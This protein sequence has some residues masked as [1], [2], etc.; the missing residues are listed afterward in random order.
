MEFVILGLIIIVIIATINNFKNYK[1]ENEITEADDYYAVDF[2]TDS[3][4]KMIRVFSNKGELRSGE[5]ITVT[6]DSE[7]FF[8]R[9]YDRDGREVDLKAHKLSWS[10]PCNVVKFATKNGLIN[11][12]NCSVKGDWARNI[13][14]RYQGGVSFS[15][16]MIFK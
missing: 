2:L 14:V 3:S 7:T 15:W 16:K 6:G 11:V 8:V 1:K 5:A 13:S 4:L 10:S 12:I 9:G